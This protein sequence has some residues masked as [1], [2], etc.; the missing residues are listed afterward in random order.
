MILNVRERLGALSV[1]RVRKKLAAL[2]TALL[3]GAVSFSVAVPGAG[4]HS[5]TKQVTGQKQVCTTEWVQVRV[6]TNRSTAGRG[7]RITYTYKNE[8]R[9]VCSWVP[10]VYTVNRAHLHVTDTT[11]R[12][13]EAAGVKGQWDLPSGG[14]QDCPLVANRTARWWPGVLPVGQL[15]SG[16]TPLP[17]VA[18]VRRMLSPAVMTTWAWWSSRST[19]ALA[20]VLGMSSS[21][22][23]G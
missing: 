20:M 4:A 18:W 12:W 17:A 1:V 22:P 10:T 14:Q 7:N 16:V 2:A 19:V 21:N 23:A 6:A 9:E 3:L 8:L 13:I 11:C 5:A 15:V